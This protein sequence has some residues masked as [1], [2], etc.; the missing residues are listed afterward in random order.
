MHGVGVL[1]LDLDQA[2]A[3]AHA[4]QVGQLHLV[5]LV[6][7]ELRQQR[8]GEEYLERAGRRQPPVRVVRGQHLTRLGVRDHPRPR[9]EPLRQRRRA[10]R[11]AHLGAGLAE[12]G[13]AHGGHRGQRLRFL[14]LLLPRPVVCKRG[15][16][17]GEQARG[18]QRGDRRGA[19]AP[20]GARR[21]GRGF[22]GARSAGGGAQSTESRRH[23]RERIGSG[24]V[25]HRRLG[26]TRPSRRLRGVVPHTG[27]H[28]A[29]PPR[30]LVPARVRGVELVHLVHL[31]KKTSGKTQA[32]SPSTSPATRPRTSGSISRSRSPRFSWGRGSGCSGSVPCGPCGAKAPRR[33]GRMG[34]WLPSS[35]WSR[36]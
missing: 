26:R 36:C 7:A 19:P 6:L 27:S 17:G 31:C 18:Q 29:Q 8:V 25:R 10:R 2:A 24:T 1:L 14:G 13:A 35:R 5:G 16:R 22:G 15:V 30:V 33:N 9:G 12:L 11:E 4:R 3:L 32:D 23:G 21:R 20:G 34:G 28:E